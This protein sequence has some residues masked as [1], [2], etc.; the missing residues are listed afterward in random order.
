[1]LQLLKRELT[2][3]QNRMKQTADKKRS[4]REFEVGDKVYL[5]VKRFLQH[6]FST[7]SVSKLNHTWCWL[8]WARLLTN[9][10]YP[11][12]YLTT[13]CSTSHC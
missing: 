8:K 10:S 2:T 4:E 13:Q 5:K 6:S 7:L 12:E 11:K 9:Y 1:M 3:T